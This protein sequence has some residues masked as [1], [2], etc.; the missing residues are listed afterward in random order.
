MSD[1]A[2]VL[3]HR[4]RVGKTP[5]RDGDRGAGGL[6]KFDYHLDESDPGMLVLGRQ[7]GAFVAVFSA[8]GASREGVVEATKEDHAGWLGEANFRSPR[9]RS[10]VVALG[11]GQLPRM[12]STRSSRKFPSPMLSA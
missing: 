8:L 2:R 5:L 6:P 10:H 4:A 3:D 1:K 11:L 9:R 12:P 7:D